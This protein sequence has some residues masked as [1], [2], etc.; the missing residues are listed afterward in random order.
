MNELQEV[1]ADTLKVHVAVKIEVIFFMGQENVLSFLAP[2][3][4]VGYY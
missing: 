2:F 1:P 4:V 3:E